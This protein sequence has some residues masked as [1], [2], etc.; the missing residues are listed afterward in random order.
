MQPPQQ[1][2]DTGTP[3][4]AGTG[5]TPLVGGGGQVVSP[6]YRPS[7]PATEQDGPTAVPAGGAP[8]PKR[9]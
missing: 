9:P 1:D 8:Q 5:N 7:P 6:G 2:D 4:P 3:R